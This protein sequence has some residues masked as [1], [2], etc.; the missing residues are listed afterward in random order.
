MFVRHCEQPLRLFKPG[1][2]P[3]SA[4]MADFRDRVGARRTSLSADEVRG[5]EA[6]I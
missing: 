3:D 4:T 5:N 1:T 2:G 6:D